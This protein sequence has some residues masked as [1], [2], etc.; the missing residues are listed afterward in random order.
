MVEGK[1]VEKGE[2][3][4]KMDFKG[5][6]LTYWEDE[7]DRVEE[8][9]ESQYNVSAP[10]I[11]P[12]MTADIDETRKYFAA[13]NY[14]AAIPYLNNILKSNPE[15]VVAYLSLAICYYNMQEYQQALNQLRESSRINPGNYPSLI[16]YW[17]VYDKLGQKG[18]AQ[19]ALS[20]SIKAL[21][22]TSPTKD[23]LLLLQVLEKIAE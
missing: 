19:E 20:E 18:K 21:K 6:E 9:G 11:S 7:I 4:I 23:N 16:Y 22:K 14:S 13:G 17:L 12:A 3:F 10:S 5:V 2:G 8:D 15:S 1:I